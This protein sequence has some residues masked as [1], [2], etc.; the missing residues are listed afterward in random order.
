MTKQFIAILF[1]AA[2]LPAQQN[3][4]SLEVKGIGTYKA[5][6]DLGVLTVEA[7]VLDRKFADAVKGLNAKGEKLTAQLQTIGFKKEEIKTT[8]FSVGKNIV[9][10]N[11][12]NVDKGYI[13][14]QNI[15]V[16]FPNTKEKISAIIN[17]FM[18][19]ENEV[20]FSFHFLLSEGRETQVR[21][22]LLKR[23][24]EDAQ[25]RA[26]VL[27]LAAGQTAG[28]IRQIS[29]GN[30]HSQAPR[31]LMMKSAGAAN[32]F[33]QGFDVKEMTLSDEVTVIWDLK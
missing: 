22:E 26:K 24:V 12:S 23:A 21:E 27:L 15:S 5:M 8:D 16:E 13:A 6:P 30:M 9:W 4:R 28:S 33:S 2:L 1:L 20:R 7:T 11:N 32:E 31:P 19:S 29:Y 10:E 25:A 14:R 3:L 17:L 18:G